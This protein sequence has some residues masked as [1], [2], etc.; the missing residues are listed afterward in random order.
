M[1]IKMHAMYDHFP[2]LNPKEGEEYIDCYSDTYVEQCRAPGKNIAMLLEPK[3]MI[4]PAYSYVQEHQEYFR[5]IFCHDSWLLRLP[6]ARP[7]NWAEVWLTTDSEKTKGISICSSFKDWCPLHKARTRLAEYYDQHG[8]VDTFGNYKGDRDKWVDAK[9]YLEHY[10]F[11]IV[12]ENDIDNL[13]YTEKILNCFA[14][15]TVPIY[16][17]SP[18]IGER[19]NADGIIQAKD[20]DQVPQIVAG[21]DIENDYNSRMDAINDNFTRLDYY[22]T[23]W[24]ERFFRDY[25]DILEGLQHE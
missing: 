17:G 14:T 11:S 6:Q 3:S 20:C 15:K 4:A 8:G 5:Y 13:W 22:R 10:R 21:L 7:L 16:V 24:K 12:V 23:P 9:E 18:T 25:G 2:D 19:F 1:K